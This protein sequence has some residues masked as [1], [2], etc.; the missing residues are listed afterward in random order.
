VKH[1]A[2][3]QALV[4]LGMSP[5]GQRMV[6]EVSDDGRG[7]DAPAALR[8]GTGTGIIGMRER[9]AAHGGKMVIAAAPEGGTLIRFELP[10]APSA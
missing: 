4:H 3:T 9:V 2:A 1:A 6:L 8:T 10:L 7:F 5:D